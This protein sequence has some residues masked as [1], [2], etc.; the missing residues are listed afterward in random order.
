MLRALSCALLALLSSAC[1]G[2]GSAPPPL[3]EVQDWVLGRTLLDGAPLDLDVPARISDPLVF[4]GP[5]IAVPGGAALPLVRK[6][7]DGRISLSLQAWPEGLAPPASP[8]EWLLVPAG[9]TRLDN[10]LQAQ[11]LR[12]ELPGTGE[13]LTVAF[14]E[15][16][17]QP[18]QLLIQLQDHPAKGLWLSRIR[19]VTSTGFQ[20]RLEAVQEGPPGALEL[21]VLA[22]AGPASG[23]F[24]LRDAAG[25]EQG[26]A[27]SLYRQPASHVPEPDTGYALR[28][29]GNPDS[30]PSSAELGLLE[31]GD[32]LFAQALTDAADAP[33][34]LARAPDTAGRQA[35]AGRPNILLVFLEDQGAQ[36]GAYGTPGLST[37]HFDA[38][39][40]RGVL[41]RKAYITLGTCSGAKSAIYTGL[42][43]HLIGA[44]ANVQDYI[45]SAEQLAAENP[46]WLRAPGS[47]YNRYRIREAYGTIVERLQAA[48]Y[49][50]GLQNK[51]HVAPHSKF[52]FD[53]WYPASDDHYGA[54]RD[55]LDQ[56]RAHGGNWF[57][58]HVI[59]EPHRPFPNAEERALDIDPAALQLPGHLADT[60]AIRQDWA[61]YFQAIQDG[62]DKLGQVL[63]ALREAGAEDD[64]V[65]IVMGDHGPPYHR[66]KYSSYDLGLHVPMAIAGP[67]IA[68]RALDE[69]ISGVDLTPTLLDLAGLSPMPLAHG[70]S[71]APLLLG[72]TQQGPR[73][74]A[75]GSSRSD[76]SLTD[77]RYRLIFMPQPGDTLLPE[78]ARDFVPWRNRVYREILQRADEPLMASAYRFLDLADASL[79]R[80]ERPR[81]EF[82]DSQSDPWEVARFGLVAA[83]DP[84]AGRLRQALARLLDQTGD[85]GER[86]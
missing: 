51:L 22:L 11:A 78:D 66:G 64:T 25:G 63:A 38:V 72:H 18:P 5:A 84:Q 60:P 70:F 35:D 85:R 19:E 37:P 56:A 26:T 17:A 75:L 45:G 27:F 7:E 31:L 36:A 32:H 53:R 76:R 57:L 21:G 15:A 12:V 13:W 65:I 33:T 86:P 44:T 43:N 49:F 14:A 68:A 69:V 47:A 79:P 50:S 62:D 59:N 52:P 40:A 1:G 8:V 61:E 55:F 28:L 3:P 16:F 41:L 74:Y 30:M 54:V 83:D 20:L 29:L 24:N 2:G 80:Y 4:T 58:V 48:G 81:E 34:L 42:Y 6:R 77:G 71:F 10:G 46:D 39:A 67:G 82:Y 73:R 9:E 23:F